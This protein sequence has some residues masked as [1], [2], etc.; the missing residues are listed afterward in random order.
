MDTATRDNFEVRLPLFEGPFDLLLFFIERDEL[1]IYDIPIAKITNDFLDYLHHLDTLNV[2]VASEFILV[3]ATLMR[4]KSKMLLPRPQV[5]EQG[6]EIDPR[7]ELV[8]HLLEYK[9]YKSVID[10]FHKMEET[11]LMKEKRGNLMKE[12]KALAESSNVEAELQDVDLFKLMTVFEKVLK[13]FEAEKNK[14]VHQVI[15]YPYTIEEQKNY[16]LN[17]VATKERVSFLDIVETYKTRIALIFNFL[18]ILELLAVGQLGIQVGE[19]YNN[20][21]LTKAGEIQATA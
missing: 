19:G 14:P 4:I 11:E 17:E 20:F 2:D 9:K 18:S 7:E 13:R 8:K 5:D 12:L 1:D 10:S 21:W 15:Q 16:L 6:N 3:A